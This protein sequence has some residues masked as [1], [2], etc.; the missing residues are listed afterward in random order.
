MCLDQ[1][2][3]NETDQNVCFTFKYNIQTFVEKVIM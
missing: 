2:Y 1:V 3:S